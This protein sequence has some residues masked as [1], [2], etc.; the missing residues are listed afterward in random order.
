M[1][2]LRRR[3]T[4]IYRVLVDD[5]DASLPAL[6]SIW[7]GDWTREV[8]DEVA[9]P[10]PAN[11]ARRSRAVGPAS[12]RTCLLAAMFCATAGCAVAVTTTLGRSRP[13]SRWRPFTSR[14]RIGRVWRPALDVPARPAARR[15]PRG[16]L[17]RGGPSSAARGQGLHG[18]LRLDRP[19]SGLSRPSMRLGARATT[20]AASD[21]PTGGAAQDAVGR[22]RRSL[23]APQIRRAGSKHSEFA[24]E[25]ATR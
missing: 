9:V 17:R 25:A 16:R 10:A 13:S 6:G 22:A 11:E 1:T 12:R 20:P 7:E 5:V 18:L 2:R 14:S 23:A 21:Q 19:A 3:P 24:F 8:A 4:A 15:S